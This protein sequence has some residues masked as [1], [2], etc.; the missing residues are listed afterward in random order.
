MTVE[1]GRMSRSR[2]CM[3]EAKSIDGR[4]EVDLNEFLDLGID[5]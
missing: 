2:E 1:R 3:V 5:L 4:F